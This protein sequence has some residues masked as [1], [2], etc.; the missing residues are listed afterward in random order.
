M[1]TKEL[2]AF[3]TSILDSYPFEKKS[4]KV[5]MPGFFH[6]ELL[7]VGQ[8]PGLLKADVEGDQ[9]YLQAFEKRDV[10]GMKNAYIEALKSE[11]G[12]IGTFIVD[13]IGDDWSKISFTNV[14]KTPFNNNEVAVESLLLHTE[15][16]KRQIEL[17]KPRY[18][19]AIGK[20]AEEALKIIDVKITM[21]LLH[22]SFL[23]R[24]GN[25]EEKIKEYSAAMEKFLFRYF[26]TMCDV[27]RYRD[28]YLRYVWK[29]VRKFKKIANYP[30]FFYVGDEN[31]SVLTYDGKKATKM[32]FDDV[33]GDYEERKRFFSETEGSIYESD[34]YKNAKYL[35]EEKC[36]FSRNQKTLYFDIETNYSFDTIAV[37]EPVISVSGITHLGEIYTWAWREDLEINVVKKDAAEI[38]YFNS[39]KEMLIDFFVFM[40]N[41]HFDILCGWNSEIFDVPYLLH[42]AQKLRIDINLISPFN[43]TS[44]SMGEERDTARFRIYGTNHVDLMKVYKKL[45]YDKRPESYSLNAV[46]TMLFSESKHKVGNITESW[47][48][49]LTRLIEYNIQD[50]KLLKKIDEYTRLT[51]FLK[52]LQSISTCPLD[53][54]LYNKNVVDCYIL[55][56]YN[57]V[58]VFPDIKKDVKKEEY[59]GAITGKLIFD[60]TGNFES[61]AAVAGMFSNVAVPDF[62]SMY[63][64]IYRTFNI[65]PETIVDRGDVKIEDVSFTFEKE[66]VIPALFDNLLAKRKEYES[67]R[68]S[69]SRESIDWYIYSNYQAGIKQIANSLYGLTAYPYFRLYDPRVAR[70][71][72]FI[73]RH[74]IAHSWLI[75]EKVGAKPLYGD[76]DSLF[77]EFDKNLS[78]EEVILKSEELTNTLNASFGEFTRR[79]KNND[80]HFLKIETEKIFKKLIFTG[81]KKKYIGKL[82]YK[83]GRRTEEIFGRGIE[84]VKRDTPKAFKI[85]LKAVV[86]KLI[87][88]EKDIMNYVNG[89][90]KELL[91]TFKLQDIGISKNISKHLADYVKT[92][93]Q[94][95][96]AVN[97]SNKNLGTTFGKAD[98]PKL[99]YVNSHKWQDTKVIAL[100]DE[101]TELPE[102]FSIDWDKY[103]ENFIDKKL[104]M[105][106]AV[107]NLSSQRKL[108]EFF[109]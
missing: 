25:Y 79:F 40:R 22:P 77:V 60:A 6:G 33:G 85:L 107:Q 17:L 89:Y 7:F 10:M 9:K 4:Q 90:K 41:A 92:I 64:S 104:E 11:K 78:E 73:G 95:I 44:F 58:C 109:N 55:K 5:V 66:G 84:L 47:K 16:L 82:F 8:N 99:F 70:T 65:S 20:I 86:E 42:R 96:R 71:I 15:I 1:N 32:M 75:A 49:D 23:K 91:A 63:P 52:T 36:E 69:F 88:D 14:L 93:P 68:D 21:A 19:F 50:C 37:P 81:V 39:E 46:S 83:K 12:T 28:V 76:T 26:I 29:G 34:V 57:G 62:S 56:T 35:I 98:I 13:L 97:F 3:N 2:E 74:L 38:R 30:F 100:S 54:C 94:H 53:L 27:I 31:G 101:A 48:K 24:N 59:E 103:F 105:F 61:V 43:E 72:T 67:L 51:D 87:N 106:S 18:I 108:G 102:G 80:R 45:T